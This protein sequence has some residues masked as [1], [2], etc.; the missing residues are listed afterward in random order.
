MHPNHRKSTPLLT[1]HLC[2]TITASMATIPTR[3]QSLEEAAMSIL[4]QVDELHIYLNDFNRV[5][6]FLVHEKIKV[7]QSQ[8]CLGDIGDAGKFYTSESV[9]GY[10][11]TIDDD[12]VYPPDYVS[13]MIDAIKSYKRKAVI[14]IH[15]RR[16]KAFP[17]KSYYHD[18]SDSYKYD[19]QILRDEKL[20]I[21]GTGVMAY[22]TDTIR[23]TIQDFKMSNMSDIWVGIKCLQEGIPII[24][25]SHK[26]LWVTLSKKVDKGYSIYATL[27]GKDQ[28][29]TK[30]INSV[31]W[32]KVL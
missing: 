21:G 10:H 12:I 24:C 29:Q 23:F 2:D 6:S 22:H 7:F 4:P 15:G 3:L 1:N 27:N 5:P 30:L 19:S 16:F 18:I 28:Y 8:K 25:V 17:I 14:T 13:K 11:F 31:N 32:D 26:R 9:S 20:H